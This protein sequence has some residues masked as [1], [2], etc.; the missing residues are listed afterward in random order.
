[1]CQIRKE[2]SENTTKKNMGSRL[3]GNDGKLIG[4]FRMIIITGISA[5]SVRQYPHNNK[6][7]ES[8][9]DS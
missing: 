6:K 2:D 5:R 7:D 4:G 1:M 3:R 8:P 9:D